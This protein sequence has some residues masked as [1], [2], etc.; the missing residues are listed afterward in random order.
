M[1]ARMS[2]GLEEFLV[3]KCG[4]VGTTVNLGH[5]VSVVF[6]FC[7]LLVISVGGIQK[8]RVSNSDLCSLAGPWFIPFKS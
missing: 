6:L 5:L 1:P 7:C 4:M 3:V 2:L 8:E